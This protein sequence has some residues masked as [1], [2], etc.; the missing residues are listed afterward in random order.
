MVQIY[1]DKNIL[2]TRKQETKHDNQCNQ[3]EDPG[4]NSYI[5]RHQILMKNP[6][7]HTGKRKPASLAGNSHPGWLHIKGSK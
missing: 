7:T 5:Y 1:N 4:I 6:E 3:I 2:I